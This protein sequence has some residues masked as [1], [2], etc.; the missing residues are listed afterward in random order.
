MML[1]LMPGFSHASARDD[2]IQPNKD[3]VLS[4]QESQFIRSLP[5][6]KVMVDDNFVPL[7][8][9]DSKTGSYQ[10]ISVD[11]FR[12]IADKLGLKYQWLH[13]P[14][15]SWSDKVDL[16][17]KH[18]VDLLM[19]VSFTTERAKA[20]IYTKSFY[21]TYYGVIGKKDR[22]I[23]L[24]SSY[25]LASYKIG[26][27]KASA[28]IPFIQPFVP[29]AQIIAYD[30]Q[31]E[32]YQS[33]RN[34][35]VDVALQN[36][37]VFMEDRFNLGF[38]DLTM[39]HTIAESPRKYSYYL[40]KNETHQKLTEIIDRYM[41]GVDYSR[42]VADYERG[43]D[44]LILR[45]SEQ[46]HQKKLLLIGIYC[47]LPLL[48]LFGMAYLKHRKVAVKLAATLEQVQKHHQAL[49]S[50]E[51]RYRSF[52]ETA[53]EGILVAQGGAMKFV[54]PAIA[55][56]S[57]YTEEELLSVSFLD[58]V[59][60]DYREMVINN[61]TKRL[62][63]EATGQKYEIEIVKKDKST[64]WVEISGAK[65]EWDGQPATLTFVTDI[66]ERKRNLDQLENLSHRLQLATKSV[67]LGV[68]DWDV[69]SNQMI[70][71]DRMFELYEI[72]PETDS[73]SIDLWISRLHPED[74]DA[75]VAACYAA[76]DGK[77]DF[78]T[79]FRIIHPGDIETVKYIRG[80]GIVLRGA[81]GAAE[82]MIGINVDVSWR[83]Q[84]E[85][86]NARL[87][88]RLRA[89]L[90]NLPMMAWLKDTESR[91]EMV[92]E[93][94]A[95]ACGYTVE[96][97]IGKTDL[98]LF[99]LEMAREY[100][101]DDRE[102][103]TTGQSKQV[104]EQ[105][106][107]PDGNRWHLTYKTP[108]FD[109][110]GLV[111]GTTGIAQ[112]ITTLKEAKDKRTLL[113][114]QLQQSQ[115][116]ESVG[117]LAG[118]VAHDFN[119]LLTVILGGTY[120]ALMEVE[121]GQ[122]LHEYITSIK[123][124]AEKSAELT[125]QLL[126]FARKQTIMP[127]VLDL[128]QT[129]AG[130]IKMLQRLIGE[131]VELNWQPEAKL[132]PVKADP[133]Q[134]DQILANL[135]VNARDSITDIGTIAIKTGN[136]IVDGGFSAEH[137]GFTPGEYVHISVCDTGCGMDKETMA[138]IFEPFFT[139]K[140]VGEGTG[141]GLATVY[142]A[143]KQN[144][145]FISVHSE[146][147]LGTTFTIYLPRHAGASD[148]ILKNDQ[149]KPAPKGLETILLVE[150]EPAILNM[151][152]MLL[153]KQGY[154]VLAA[155]SPGEAGRLAS[156]QSGKIDLLLTDVIMPE[157]NG[158]DLA[159]NLM[160]LNPLLKCL[161]MSGYTANVISQHGVLDEGMHFIQKPFSLPDLATKVRTVLDS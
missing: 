58:F 37:N 110:Q 14:K 115:K 60:A 66:T 145:G 159:K 107:T 28:I 50:S 141:L 113:E 117:R 128:N 83:R 65:I 116:M 148:R 73:H 105:I 70:W 6:L 102:I 143:V 82:R 22:T 11:L 52:I 84:A 155:S 138:Q 42:L 49:Q 29:A 24:K 51:H 5:P 95:K 13:N 130:M 54:N 135:C 99:P 156:E 131:D 121:P 4:E 30:N 88:L 8:T 142:G 48:V 160:S 81:D 78:D 43:E 3:F 120:L 61:H 127:K 154:T 144:N 23:I 91:L 25:D 98:D 157:M 72:T 104:E 2:L 146:P 89:I 12:H 126:A 147:G 47:T 9:Y 122:P 129:V 133:S 76:L 124:A 17:K 10:G 64:G 75:A 139:T 44:E 106:A 1:L 161:F 125:Q 108:L 118:G 19:P 79:V 39:I 80:T 152:M 38:V 32:L 77:H 46:K 21:D 103:C 67:N 16:F 100:V 150:D 134:I 149:A 20:G 92:N 132:W 140:G 85:I 93:P 68:W 136:K 41:S 137:A 71:D 53:T 101:A 7:S 62:N 34:G 45:Y 56:M 96:E 63:G 111:V 90:D 15:L 123:K 31:A 33:L 153:S 87:L 114:N 151:T 18:E 94:F 35:Q 57:G 109:E 69:R 74:K 86:A 27:T 97:C 59:Q 158:K 26:V 119:N 112:D 40:N 36:R 55:E